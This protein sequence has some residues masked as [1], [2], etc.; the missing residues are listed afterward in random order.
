MQ[1][2]TA[3]TYLSGGEAFAVTEGPQVSVW[4]VRVAERAGCV[5]RLLAAQAGEPLLAVAAAPAGGAGLIGVAGGDRAL[6]VYDDRRWRVLSKWVGCAKY[7]VTGISFSSIDPGTAY[8]TGL[9]YEVTCGR[10]DSSTG[11]GE[12]GRLFAFRGDARWCGV[13]KAEGRDLLAGWSEAGNVFVADIVQGE[14]EQLEAVAP[15]PR[16]GNDYEGKL[17]DILDL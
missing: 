5:Q 1:N 14:Q 3:L 16:E 12:G 7:E 6:S 17:A 4:D 10:W 9:D 11:R 2:P 15:R 8:I 13:S